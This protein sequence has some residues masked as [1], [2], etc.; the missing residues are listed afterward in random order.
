MKR[1]RYLLVTP[2]ALLFFLII[3]A[4]VAFSR[5]IISV[6]TDI[7]K[8]DLHGLTGESPGFEDAGA[9]LFFR[10]ADVNRLGLEELISIPGIGPSTA[11]KILM[12]R[13]ETGFIL[14]L[15]EL[16]MPTGPL[17]IRQFGLIEG[18]L[19]TPFAVTSDHT[20]TCP[21]NNI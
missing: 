6:P 8:R 3:A 11:S 4:L 2:E 10:K 18:Y 20:D 7:C 16:L 12:F 1:A 14:C 13:E 19:T 5:D 21:G 15:D 17:N 9:F